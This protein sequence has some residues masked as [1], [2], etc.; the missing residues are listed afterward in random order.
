MLDPVSSVPVFDAKAKKEL[1]IMDMSDTEAPV[2][3]GKKIILLCEKI[4]REDI[5]VVTEGR[6]V[7]EELYTEIDHKL[8]ETEQKLLELEG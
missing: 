7:A 2:E 8:F 6:F 4:L 3:G 5:G 1:V